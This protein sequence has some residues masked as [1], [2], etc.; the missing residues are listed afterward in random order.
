MQ[1][2]IQGL[3]YRTLIQLLLCVCNLYNVIV[4]ATGFSSTVEVK[5][6]SQYGLYLKNSEPVSF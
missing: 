3:I 6:L 2:D 4:D 1:L 5:G